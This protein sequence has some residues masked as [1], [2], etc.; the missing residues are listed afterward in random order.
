[1]AE[2]RI[3]RRLAAILA[4]DVVGYGRLMEQDEAATLAVLKVRRH[5]VVGPLVAQHRG[6]VVKVMGDGVLIEF[7]SAVDAVACAVEMHKRFADANQSLPEERRIVLRIGINLGDVIVEGSDIYGDG[8]NIAARLEALAEPGSICLSGK[9]YDE[10]RSKGGHAFEDMGNVVLKNIANP[11]R[12]F[13]ISAN[14]MPPSGDIPLSLPAKPSIAVLPFTN[15]SGDPEQR[16]F[17][18]GITEDIITEL[19]RARGLFVIARNSSFSYRDKAVDVRRIAHELGVRYVVEGSVRRMAD[20]IRITAQLIDAV[21]GNHLWSE[22]FDRNIDDLFAIQDEVTQTIVTT[23]TGRLEDAEI[24]N[25]SRKQTD[26]LSAYDCVLR[27]VE[28]LRAYGPDVN[29]RARELFEQAI[30]L[31]PRYAL[32]H[33][34][35]ALALVIENGYGNASDVIKQRALEAAAAAVRLDPRESRCHIFLGQVHRF[36]LEYDLAISHLERGLALNPNDATGMIHLATVL[37]VCGRAEEG[38]EILHRAIKLDPYL[39]FYWGTLATCLYAL[40]RYEEAFAAHRKLG[41]DK[42]PWQLAKEAACLA[43]LGRT[44]EAN[45]LAAEVL[46]RKPGFSVRAEMPHYKHPADAEN[47]RQGLLRAGLPE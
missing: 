14:A 46:R 28:Q 10:V 20:R 27:G 16:Y 29:R 35:L 12:A 21:S 15:M 9:V 3:Q 19:S 17:A 38:V 26:S 22:R 31:D 40:R 4:A 39:H 7:A 25:A 44:D 8:V 1:L 11:V 30:A 18:D 23:M 45:A 37:A 2:E 34:Y 47:L 41:S 13:K 33:A 42:S 36:R 6:R 32:A 24:W 43:Q 5:E